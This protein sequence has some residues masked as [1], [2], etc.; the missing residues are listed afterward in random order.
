[1]P[2]M[3]VAVVGINFKGA[4]ATEC[5]VRAAAGY[6]ARL[7][8]EPTNRYD[9][10]AVQVHVLGMNVGFIPKTHNLA[11]ATAMDSGAEPIAIVTRA[12]TT[13]TRGRIKQEPLL[14]VT[15]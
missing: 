8:R 7:V 12:A 4:A 3:T 1:M 6:A 15:W 11:L 5:I 2:Q 10:N 13:D 9:S 14:S